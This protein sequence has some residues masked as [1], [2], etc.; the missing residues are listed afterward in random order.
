MRRVLDA[1]DTILQRLGY[2]PYGT[3]LVCIGNNQ[4]IRFSGNELIPDL[5]GVLYDFGARVYAPWFSM[6]FSPDP[7]AHRH[8]DI[9]PYSYCAGNPIRFVD[10]EESIG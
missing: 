7:L 10:P 4:T 3:P 9:S 5:Y 8:Y 6:F 1:E 2:T